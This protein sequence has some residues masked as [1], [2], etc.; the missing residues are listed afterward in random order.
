MKN[1]IT[2]T[3]N[4]IGNLKEYIWEWNS[5]AKNLNLGDYPN[6]GVLAQE[7]LEVYPKAVSIGNDGYY[8]VDY[9]KIV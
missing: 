2:P 7:A 9:S 8:R 4:M 6:M 1:N 5:V 3:G